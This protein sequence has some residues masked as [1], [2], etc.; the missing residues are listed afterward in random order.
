MKN[1]A[2][3]P[4]PIPT[5]MP[6]SSSSSARWAAARFSGSRSTGRIPQR[7]DTC[8]NAARVLIYRAAGDQQGRASGDHQRRRLGV[9]APIDLDFERG[10]Q[11]SY[12]PDLVRAGVDELLAT[13]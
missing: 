6:G 8:C 12:S 4:V 5:T 7:P 10:S 9:D 11:L 2:V 3:E 13:E 1:R